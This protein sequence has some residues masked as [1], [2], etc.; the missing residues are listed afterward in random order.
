MKRSVQIRIA[1]A[2]TSFVAAAL[3]CVLPQAA[4]CAPRQ[5]APAPIER[6]PPQPRPAAGPNANVPAL[7][8]GPHRL[9]RGEHLAEWMTQHSSLSPQQQQQALEHEP[10]FQ[11]LPQE[12]QQRMRSRLAQLDAMDPQRRQQLLARNEA[13]E[14]LT[15]DQRAQFRGAMAQLG[16][17]PQDQRR[18]VARTFHQLLELPAE[19]RIPAYSSGRYGPPLSDAQRHVLFELLRVEPLLPSSVWERPGGGQAR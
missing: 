15:L 17:L 4:F 7:S 3:L 19:Q 5:Q 8:N 6:R 12:T 9:P 13:I 11:E 14:H 10:G 2:S 18:V 16:A 1:T